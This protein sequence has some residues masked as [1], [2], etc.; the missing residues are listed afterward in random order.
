MK[1]KMTLEPHVI[2]SKGLT[3][4]GEVVLVLITIKA[5]SSSPKQ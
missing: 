2:M 3:F 5:N 1:R 4:P